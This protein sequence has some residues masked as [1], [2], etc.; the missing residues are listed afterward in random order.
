MSTLGEKSP[1]ISEQNQHIYYSTS[2]EIDEL[3]S[4]TSTYNEES[5]RVDAAIESLISEHAEIGEEEDLM[6]VFQKFIASETPELEEGVTILVHD[7]PSG[8]RLSPDVTGMIE[9]ITSIDSVGYIYLPMAFDRPKLNQFRNKGYCFIHFHDA[10][11]A[12]KF[13]NGISN[14]GASQQSSA[15]DGLKSED[16]P[17]KMHAVF[18]KYQGVSTNLHNLLDIESKKWRPKNSHVCVKTNSGLA[19]IPLLGLRTLTK[20]YFKADDKECENGVV[21][22]DTEFTPLA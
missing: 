10:N 18:A 13:M 2:E 1:E 4:W 22:I 21:E 7:V 5:K 9:S 11:M 12:E 20:R 19:K 14:H 16:E 15:D 6:Y 3:K 17:R 8:Y